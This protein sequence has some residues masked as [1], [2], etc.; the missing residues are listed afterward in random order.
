MKFPS[1]DDFMR[2]PNP[3]DRHALIVSMIAALSVSEKFR[4]STPGDIYD[5]MVKNTINVHEMIA[6]HDAKVIADSKKS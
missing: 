1:F 2:E 5:A 3:D 4:Y 6:S